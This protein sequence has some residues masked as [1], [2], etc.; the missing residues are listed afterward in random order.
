MI[1]VRSEVQILPGPPPTFAEQNVGTRQRL[2]SNRESGTH[3][4]RSSILHPCG[5]RGARAPLTPPSSLGGGAAQRTGGVAQLGE[6]LLCKQEVVGSIPITS[7][8]ERAKLVSSA[9][10]VAQQPREHPRKRCKASFVASRDSGALA[11]RERPCGERRTIDRSGKAGL[12]MGA[13]SWVFDL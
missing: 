1:S 11:P 8:T 5:F 12:P 9:A 7:T 10:A 13:S 2:R 4:E 6:R 3:A